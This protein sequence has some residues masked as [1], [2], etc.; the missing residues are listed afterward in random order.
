MRASE[1]QMY[2]K[3][4]IL[5]FL[6]LLTLQAVGRGAVVWGLYSGGSLVWTSTDIGNG[7]FELNNVQT[8]EKRICAVDPRDN[9]VMRAMN[10]DYIGTGR[11]DG[12][13]NER[14]VYWNEGHMNAFSFT[15][16]RLQ[17]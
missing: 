6:V 14:R 7:E 10:G 16:R 4:P 5:L 12:A 9:F 3:M 15:V 17:G 11:G 2:V 1:V 8:G 13:D